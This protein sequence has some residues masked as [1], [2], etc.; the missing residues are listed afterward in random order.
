MG[1]RCTNSEQKEKGVLNVD[2]KSIAERLRALRGSKTVRDVARDCNISHSALAMYEN[3]QR[4]PKDEIKI[5]LAKY[6]NTSIEDLFF[7]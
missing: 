4:I 5:K 2:K 6:Y 7:T 1:V 3:G